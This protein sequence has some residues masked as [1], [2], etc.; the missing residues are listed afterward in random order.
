MNGSMSM[1]TE[2]VVQKPKFT[3]RRLPM[4]GEKLPESEVNMEWPTQAMLDEWPADVSLKSITFSTWK[5][6][7]SA[8]S[9]VQCTLSTQVHSPLFDSH[10]LDRFHT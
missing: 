1:Y 5:Q 3:L 7:G 8:I 4:W 9:S 2:P 10:S 6:D